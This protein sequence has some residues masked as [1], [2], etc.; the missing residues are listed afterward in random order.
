MA[1]IAV[2][3]MKNKRNLVGFVATLTLLGSTIFS[4]KISNKISALS[5]IKS[6][7]GICSQRVGQ[8]Y[9]A[10]LI[11]EMGS[12][13]LSDNFFQTTEECVAEGIEQL[14]ENFTGVLVSLISQVNEMA[15]QV[16][17]FHDTLGA[18]SKGT[19][20][21]VVMSNLSDRFEKLEMLNEE[22]ITAIEES[23]SSYQS[24]LSSINLAIYMLAICIPLVF[25]YG[26]LEV[27]ML[28]L[29]RLQ[30]E[31]DAGTLISEKGTDFRARSKGVIK[32]ALEQNGL[33]KCYQLFCEYEN[34]LLYVS[35]TAQESM[36][37][38]NTITDSQSKKIDEIWN[39]PE[40]VVK[41][42]PEPELNTIGQ[43]LGSVI[44]LFST[45]IHNDAIRLTFN[46]SKN[47]ISKIDREAIE[48]VFYQC[49]SYG[50]RTISSSEE[51]V[52]K[53]SFDVYDDKSMGIM[54]MNIS[55]SHFPT[56]VIKAQSGLGDI[57]DVIDL[58]LQIAL[59]LIE[60]EGGRIEFLN[61]GKDDEI[62]MSQIKVQLPLITT[63]DTKVV[64][65]VTK[66]TK[67]EILEQMRNS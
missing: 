13:Y 62:S 20:L 19:P 33:H 61:L 35:Q 16:H 46:D 53:F 66:G 4:Q 44:G 55:G 43:T 37:V 50:V 32:D 42:A 28:A 38:T 12:S 60:S 49:V 54:E 45:K 2:K 41:R 8:G 58:E 48:Q 57:E 5:Q 39:K 21:S 23:S 40:P 22:I 11:G 47:L 51:V 9:T 24:T 59:E 34:S 29:R 3:L 14:E 1:R 10:K 25:L 18:D 15:N 64:Q 27:R 17:W 26:Q 56:D 6:G 65:T 67:K 30:T 31:Q 36:K 7:L 63:A 52:K